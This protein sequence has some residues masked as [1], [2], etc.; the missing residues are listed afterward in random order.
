MAHFSPQWVV[1]IVVDETGAEIG[2]YKSHSNGK[3]CASVF[4]VVSGHKVES[5]GV[6][7]GESGVRLPG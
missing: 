1:V 4:R 7:E 5:T 6:V 3:A 2:L